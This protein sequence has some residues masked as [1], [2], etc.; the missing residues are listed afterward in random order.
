[1]AG[2][3]N[4]FG[5]FLG[6]LL[7]IFY[8][9]F[10]NYGVAIILFTIVLK[11][12]MFPFSIKQQKSMAANSKLSA[13]Q[14]E[15][16]KKYGNDRIKMNEEMQKLY[17]KEGYNPASGCLPM[18]IPFPI[19][20]GLY[21]TVVNPLSNALHLGKEAVA[22]AVAV[23]QTIPGIS[24]TFTYQNGF[25]NEMEIVRHFSVLRPYLTMFT[26]DEI[27][28][29]QS[30]SSGFNFLGLN[31]LGTPTDSA[32]VNFFGKFVSMFQTN[33]WLIPVLCLVSSIITQIIT[34]RLQ[35]G[36]QQQQGAMK[37]MLYVLPLISAVFA[38]SVPAAVGFYWIISTITSLFQVMI[39]HAFFSP[40]SLTA[41]AEAQRVA[42]LELEEVKKEPLS[43]HLR[44]S[45]AEKTVFQENRK[46]EQA[47]VK[48][49]SGQKK[50]SGKPT[51][52]SDSYLG[53]KK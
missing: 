52:G 27:S 49:E 4:F 45:S 24:G 42:L 13:K 8:Q 26:D 33:L 12:V 25:Y 14:K 19:M 46:D 41:K 51:G 2:I 37:M 18:L 40:A 31:L 47:S 5:S 28:K 6:Y 22:Q 16:Q 44:Q 3:G 30:L 38:M 32:A 29:I 10:K 20:I 23:L 17:E 34:M 7:W 53:K 15:L 48:K 11:I 9:F 1:M 21:Y 36:M 35:P 50:K 39:V 43:S